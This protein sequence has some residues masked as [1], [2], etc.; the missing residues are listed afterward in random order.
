M[1]NRKKDV[2]MVALEVDYRTGILSVRAVGKKHGITGQRVDQMAKEH[3]WERDLSARVAAKTQTKLA[4]KLVEVN[5]QAEKQQTALAPLRESA[6]DS[7]VDMLAS[8]QADLLSTHRTDI[9]QYQTMC[10]GFLNELHLQGLCD[11]DLARIGE[12]VAMVETQG[13]A[14]PDMDAVQKRLNAF[15]KILN[16]GGRADTFKKLVESKAKL[17]MLERISHGIRDNFLP[18]P[19]SPQNSTDELNSLMAIIE[20]TARG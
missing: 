1:P 12:L 20:G 16:L 9:Q 2:D 17:V 13:E 8:L 19:A 18:P 15:Y 7:R 14:Q 6:I 4:K 5:K 11:A 10:N 3:G